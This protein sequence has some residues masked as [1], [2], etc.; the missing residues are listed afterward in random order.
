MIGFLTLK[1]LMYPTDLSTD[2]AK[3]GRQLGFVT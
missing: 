2:W 1:K 3:Q